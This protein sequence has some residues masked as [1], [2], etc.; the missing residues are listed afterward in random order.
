[1]R[2]VDAIDVMLKISMVTVMVSIMLTVMAMTSCTK[3]AYDT[4][5]PEATLDAAVA[6]VQ[7]RQAQQLPSLID[8]AARDITFEDGVTESSAIAEVKVKAG[9]MLVRLLTVAE[10]LRARFPKEVEREVKAATKKTSRGTR[11]IAVAVLVDPGAWLASQRPRLAATDL[12]DGSAALSFDDEPLLAGVLTMTK[13]SAG[14][15]FR[16]PIEL[17]RENEYWPD[18]R[19]EWSVIASMMLAVEHALVDFQRDLDAGKI[20]SLDAASARVGRLVGESVVVQSIIYAAMKRSETPKNAEP[21][22]EKSSS[23]VEAQSTSPT[24]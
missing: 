6:M 1:M 3:P 4:S 17:V 23:A 9:Q 18:T 13:T 8:I 21:S 12:G 11:D 15:R 10:S 19:Y 16:V 7:Q 24:G 22:Q 20:N 14:W 2:R 5:T